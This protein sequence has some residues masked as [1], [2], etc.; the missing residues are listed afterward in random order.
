[1]RLKIGILLG[2]FLL[3]ALIWFVRDDDSPDSESL[4]E[5]TQQTRAFPVEVTKV[6]FEKVEHYLDAIGSFLPEDEVTVS[7]EVEGIVEKRFVDEGY[8]VKKGDSLI[9]IDDE[10]F[11]FQREEA[12]ASLKEAEERLKNAEL[13]LKRINRLLEEKV[14]DQQKYDDT[15]TQFNLSRATVENVKAKLKRYRKSLRDTLIVSPLGGVVSERMVSEG[16]YVKVGTNLLKIVDIDPLKLSFALPE[17]FSGQLKIGQTVEVETKAYPG[18][19]FTGDVYFISPKVNLSTRTFEVKA[20]VEN[21]NYQLKPGFFVDVKLFLDVNESAMV[22]PEGA[23][24]MREGRHVVLMVQGWK[25]IVKGVRPGKR[26]NGKVEILDGVDKD[27]LMVVS[28]LSELTDG[29]R[30]KVVTSKP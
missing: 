11:R 17:K 26:F 23:V 16:E 3:I 18:K 19:I 30:V 10:E 7:T 21:T 1:M 13:T 24:V 6:S 4:K 15:V 20:K 25:I 14:I 9:K 2:I 12:E 5:E 27:D 8:R 28:G 29:S 22:L